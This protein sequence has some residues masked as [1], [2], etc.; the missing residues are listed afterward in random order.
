[1]LR[2]VSIISGRRR[3]SRRSR[4]RFPRI[5][6]RLRCAHQQYLSDLFS[7]AV[8]RDGRQKLALQQMMASALDAMAP[9]ATI[10]A[11]VHANLRITSPPMRSDDALEPIMDAPSFPQAMYEPLRSLSNDY[12]F[13]DLAHVPSD[14]IHLLQT[15]ARFI[16]SFMVGLNP[17]MA[18]ELL[19]RGYPTDQR[20]T[21][22][23]QFWD[24][25]PAGTDAQPDIPPIHRWGAGA[26]GND[27]DDTAATGSCCSSA[28]SC[29]AAIQAR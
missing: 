18:R 8:F 5:F 10:A 13:P 9:D 28:A 21:Y 24:P 6:Q 22:F 3:S 1:M 15:N 29:C 20:G 12:L 2:F 25:A 26:L 27:R 17:E 14:S 16:E 23:Q 19:W 11:G 7:T 4:H